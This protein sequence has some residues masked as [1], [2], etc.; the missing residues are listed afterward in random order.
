MAI[1]SLTSQSTGMQILLGNLRGLAWNSSITSRKS[2]RSPFSNSHKK[3]SAVWLW[4][5]H[6]PIPKLNSSKP[7][8]VLFYPMLHHPYSYYRL[9]KP[10]GVW[11]LQALYHLLPLCMPSVSP[12]LYHPY[13]LCLPLCMTSS[14]PVWPLLLH[15][16]PCQTLTNLMMLVV[17]S[18]GV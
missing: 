8:T 11:A 17:S 7:S 10:S 2:F 16:I 12:G 15:L 18:F 6:H 9:C 1:L 14:V 5:L 3:L 13:R 4:F